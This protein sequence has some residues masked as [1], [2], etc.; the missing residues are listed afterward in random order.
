MTTTV[1]VQEAKTRL[2]ELLKSVEAGES[3]VIARA[4]KPIAE[5]RPLQRVDLVYGGFDV[6]LDDRFFE[7]LPEDEIAG[8]EGGAIAAG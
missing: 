5:L 7:S 8:W 1:N 2:S 3:I 4:G 6:V